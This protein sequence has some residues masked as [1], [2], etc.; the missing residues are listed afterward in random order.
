MSYFELPDLQVY[1]HHNHREPNNNTNSLYC[2][3]NT[4]LWSHVQ[5]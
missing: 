5:C 1:Q 3:I 4:G 2:N